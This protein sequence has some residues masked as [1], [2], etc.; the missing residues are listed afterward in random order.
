[1]IETTIV[2]GDMGDLLFHLALVGGFSLLVAVFLFYVV[3]KTH[4]D[5]QKRYNNPKAEKED[6]DGKFPEIKLDGGYLR[7]DVKLKSGIRSHK[8]YFLSSPMEFRVDMGKIIMDYENLY[9]Q[10]TVKH[11]DGVK[12]QICQYPLPMLTDI[13]NYAER[14][15]VI[16]G[17][18]IEYTRVKDSMGYIVEQYRKH[19]TRGQSKLTDSSK[20]GIGQMQR[21]IPLK[22]VR[23]QDRG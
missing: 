22:V 20:E 13:L 3:V 2:V 1:M 23:F 6:W 8:E 21:D 12:E 4:K 17:Y 10:T 11:K 9:V 15:V 5:N 19:H 14:E 18:M 16:K 7:N